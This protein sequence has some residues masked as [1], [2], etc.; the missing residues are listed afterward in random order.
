MVTATVEAPAEPQPKRAP[1]RRTLLVDVGLA[2]GLFIV[3]LLYRRHFPSDGLFYDDAWEA[4]GV[5]EGSLRQLITIGQAQ[6][7]FGLELMAWSR[8]FGHGTTTMIL[9]A[10]I[11]GA[12]G[13]ALLYLVLRRFG[14]AASIAFLLGASLTV[15]ETAITYSGRVKS[16]TSDVLVILLLCVLLPWLVKKRWSVGLAAAWFVGSIVLAA[17]SS[18]VLL[19]TVA[20]G[21]ILV[22]HAQDDRKIRL[23][24][25]GAQAVAL[26][27]L[28]AAED[29]THNVDLLAQFFKPSKAY[30]E[31]HLNPVTFGREIIEHLV[32]VTDIFPGG[33]GWV[34]VLCMI[35]A[36]VG[37]VVL[38]RRGPKAVVGRFLVLLVLLAIVGAVA[39][40][41]P[42]GPLKSTARVTLWLAPVVAFGLAVVLQR[43]YRAAAARGERMRL[44]FDVAAFGLSALVLLSAIGARRTYPPGATLATH[45]VMAQAGPQDVVIITRPTVYTFALD[46]GTPVRVRPSPDLTV[47]FMPKFADKR[48]HPIGFL[49]GSA[50]REIESALKKTN[51]VFVVHSLA[52][53]SGYKS[54]MANLSDLV[55]AQGF[56]LKRRPTVGTAQISVWQREGAVP[57]G[58]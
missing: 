4:F 22:F 42:F 51:R 15:C 19:A 49:T 41:V 55:A 33:P 58:G 44:A 13:P 35:A 36:T 29:R 52:D 48:L 28:F 32:R 34:S 43:L 5:A 27:A 56:E 20:A 53:K 16:Y 50:K 54:Y 21:A 23:I 7:G 47:G 46:A 45:S 26:V 37:L 3:A 14:Y 17:F 6:P 40:R 31:F 8:I 25:V 57:S 9:P 38:A 2:I 12:L 18:F 10:M 24:S 11:A 39:E 1:T 30:I